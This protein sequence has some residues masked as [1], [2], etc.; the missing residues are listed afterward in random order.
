MNASILRTVTHWRERGWF[1]PAMILLVAVVVG[2][3]TGPFIRLTQNA[4]MPSPVVA[5]GRLLLAFI[6]LTPLALTRYRDELQRLRRR[7]WTFAIISGFWISTH[8]LLFIY[9]LEITSVLVVIVLLNTG[10]IWAALLERIF[11]G[12]QQRFQAWVGI[13][14]TLVGSLIIGL[15]GG[16]I[17]GAET[18]YIGISLTLTGAI[19]GSV[20]ITIGRNVRQKV[21]VVPY[22]WIV[23]G[24]GG[25]LA[26]G[27]ILISGNSPFGHPLPAYRWLLILT[28][29]GQ[30]ISHTGFNYA[31]GT[32][33][34]TMV[35]ISTQATTIGS[36]V[37]A[38]FIFTEVPSLQEVVGSG[39]IIVGVVI[40]ILGQQSS[41]KAKS[42]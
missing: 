35:S 22:V 7:D 20:Y 5:S 13:G 12:T 27:A 4:G 34:A 1:A 17:I 2:S 19:A 31:L 25:V 26:L 37:A 15:A 9:A 38:Y 23:Y 30:L 39:I 10:P 33:S 29:G 32:F 16:S 11:L 41:R 14:I 28:I 6:I 36:A 18:N 3:F 42:P 21:S 40:A 8:F 24:C